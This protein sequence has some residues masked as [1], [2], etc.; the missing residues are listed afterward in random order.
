MSGSSFRFDEQLEV[1]ILRLCSE[2]GTNRLTRDCVLSL[3]VAV[4]ELALGKRPAVVAGNDKFF[5]AGANW[6]RFLPSTVQPR[7]SFRRWDRD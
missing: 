3:T 7:M 6:K 5:S 2:D 1:R 4:K